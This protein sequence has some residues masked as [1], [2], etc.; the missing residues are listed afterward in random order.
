MTVATT[1]LDACMFCGGHI[2]DPGL[3]FLVHLDGK[4]SC[5]AQHEEWKERLQEDWGGGD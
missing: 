4:P 3:G 1:T 5:R 2:A